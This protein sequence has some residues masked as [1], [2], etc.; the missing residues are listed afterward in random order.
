VVCGRVV[1]NTE[2]ETI[3]ISIEVAEGPAVHAV[4]PCVHLLKRY[5]RAEHEEIEAIVNVI[6]EASVAEYVA[7]ARAALACEAV[8]GFAVL[9]WIAV[10]VGVKV[11]YGVVGRGTFE[12]ETG[13]VVVVGY[14][15][16]V[17]VV[18]CVACVDAVWAV[19]QPS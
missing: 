15:Q 19:D 7:F 10:A 12:L 18:R 5:G 17:V 2:F 11:L 6:P 8:G 9:A 14:E 4:A 1:R 3:S 13:L 16:L